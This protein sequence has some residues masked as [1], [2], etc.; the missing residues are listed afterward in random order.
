MA[1]TRRTVLEAAKAT[2]KAKEARAAEAEGELLVPGRRYRACF[3]LN[4]ELVIEWNRD[5][6]KL[7]IR[8]LWG[9]ITVEPTFQNE[10]IVS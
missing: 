10:V 4:H 8:S 7:R 1:K 2:R 5:Y 3:H 9:S 6:S